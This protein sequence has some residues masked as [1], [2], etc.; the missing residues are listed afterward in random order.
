MKTSVKIIPR[1][2]VIR[3]DGTCAIRMRIILGHKARFYSLNIN[4]RPEDLNGI[5]VKKSDPCYRSKNMLIEK[6][7]NRAN[8]I[9]TGLK[10]NDTP[11]TFEEFDKRYLHEYNTTSFYQFADNEIELLKGKL[12]PDTIK[13]YKSQVNKLKTYRLQLSFNEISDTFFQQYE[14]FLRGTK[15][16]NP[17]TVVKSLKVIRVLLNLAVERNLLKSTTYK[18]FRITGGI[19]SKREFLTGPELQILVR[20]YRAGSLKRKYEIVLQYFLFSC[21]TGIRYRDVKDL[22]Y[23]NI[24]GLGSNEP[25]LNVVMHKSKRF[26]R[27]PLIKQALELIKPDPVCE[28][29]KVF[30]V[31]SNQP[32]NRHLK[33]IMKIAGINKIISFHCSR[34]TFATHCIELGV[35]I[36]VISNILGHSSLKVT[37]VYTKYPDKLKIKEL[38]KLERDPEEGFS[39]VVVTNSCEKSDFSGLL[40]NISSN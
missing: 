26:V 29:L 20:L 16:N 27:I 23:S 3:K 36:D 35:P 34:H 6:Q 40:N 21:Y 25:F 13:C 5:T 12:S 11:L 14:R 37:Q 28:G 31:I 19:E 24:E 39:K 1:N 2:D 32:T 4:V 22:K 17:N 10:I 15:K 9:L 8:D 38:K 30:R 33:E 7:V 18:K